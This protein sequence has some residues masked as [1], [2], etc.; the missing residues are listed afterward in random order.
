MHAIEISGWLVTLG[1]LRSSFFSSLLY[2][3]AGI[4]LS[5]RRGA[6]HTRREQAPPQDGKP[7]TMGREFYT[8]PE[9][10]SLLG[11][12]FQVLFPFSGLPD[13][14]RGRA[15]GI[16][17]IPEVLGPGF[18]LVIEWEMNH[19]PTNGT[20]NA[21]SKAVRGWLSKGELERFLRKVEG[22]DSE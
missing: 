8:E 16:W 9:A 7:F 10:R 18:E 14:A 15:V 12:R 22:P 4:V 6:F 3:G 2:R 20:R 13:G 21:H 5:P 19:H 1:R 11:Q 17:A